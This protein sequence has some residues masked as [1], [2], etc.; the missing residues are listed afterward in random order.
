MRSTQVLWHNSTTKLFKEAGLPSWVRGRFVE[1]ASHEA[2]HVAA[3]SAALGDQ[4]TQPCTYSFP[5]KDVKS[6]IALSQVLEGVGSS[7]YTG[8]AQYITTPAYL[9]V[10]ASILSTEARHA[11]WVAAAVNKYAGWG[12]AFEIPLSL[13]EVFTLAAG[14]ITSCP[15]TNPNLPVKAY[16]TLTLKDAVPGQNAIVQHGS[17][18]A[19]PTFIVFYF[20][21]S[22]TFVPID[23]QGK[24]AVPAN[25]SEQVYAVATSSGTEATDKTIIA[26]PAI[27]LF[28]RDA[29]GKLIN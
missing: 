4:A 13:N 12:S 11:S 27:L 6:F 18:S 8:A 16:P 24:V 15:S 17:T 20:G 19:D 23:G 2:T 3:L 9:T 10:A 29:A 1:I 14:Y 25:L 28:E 21:L 7:A 22:Q 5:Y 26:G